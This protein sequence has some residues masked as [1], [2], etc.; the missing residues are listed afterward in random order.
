[1]AKI[2]SEHECQTTASGK[3]Q[4]HASC[5]GLEMQKSCC[6]GEV[7]VDDYC[8]NKVGGKAEIKLSPCHSQCST[9]SGVRHKD[10]I[11]V[12]VSSAL[13][14]ITHWAAPELFINLPKF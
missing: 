7:A 4:L 13:P 9:D 6:I 5:Q 8:N 1:M 11:L 12:A 3:L 2:Y 10:I 14:A